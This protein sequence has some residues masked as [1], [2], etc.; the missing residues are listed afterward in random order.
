MI[1]KMTDENE[2]FFVLDNLR[3][4][5]KEEL[6]ALYGDNWYSSTLVDIKDKEVLVLYGN[7]EKKNNVP[8]AIGGFSTLFEESTEIACV[9]MLASKYIRKN[10]V[11]F[12]KELKNQIEIAEKKYKIMYNFI[13]KSN[14]SAKKWLKKVGFKFDNPNPERMKVRTNF[15]FFYKVTEG[16]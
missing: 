8:I 7:V 2:I 11:L 1:K 4:E 6:Q 3:K 9:W 5:D 12:L 10:G 14:K 15:E 16:I 13:Y